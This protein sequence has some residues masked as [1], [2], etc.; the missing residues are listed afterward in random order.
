[1]FKKQTLQISS[2]EREVV[3]LRSKLAVAVLGHA[4]GADIPAATAAQS[5]ADPTNDPMA[6]PPPTNVRSTV[7]AFERLRDTGRNTTPVR[8]ITDVVA[9]GLYREYMVNNASLPCG[10]VAGSA[11]TSKA[12]TCMAIF[13]KMATA[14]ERSSLKPPAHTLSDDQKQLLDGIRKRLSSYLNTLIVEKLR[15]SFQEVQIAVPRD[16]GKDKH[17]LLVSSL[18]TRMDALRKSL[19]TLTV[20]V[21]KDRW[22]D[23]FAEFRRAYEAIHGVPTGI[24]L[25]PPASTSGASANE[26]GASAKR[27]RM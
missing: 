23:T 8:T 19:P 17:Q 18:S 10:F 26:A 27:P 22:T 4:V 16:L 15:A 13:D 3:E 14:T 2:L 25:E 9:H 21:W 1:M 7:D 11:S 5:F 20:S 6:Q 12:M 24:H